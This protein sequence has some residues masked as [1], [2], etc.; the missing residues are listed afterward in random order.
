M[1]AQI[2]KYLPWVALAS[3]II[4]QFFR[5][6]KAQPP[7]DASINFLDIAGVPETEAVLIKNACYDCHSHEV[8]YPWYSNIAP[9]SFW[10]KGHVDHGIQ[11]F[12]FSE[13]GSYNEKKAHHKLEECVEMLENKSMPLKSFTWVHPEARLTDETRQV[14]IDFFN[15][16]M[17]E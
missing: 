1:K 9:I 3:L 6:D 13:F 10:L 4:I 2:L 16:K 17:N 5:I 12:N 11:K 15:K 7:V 8:E 14:L